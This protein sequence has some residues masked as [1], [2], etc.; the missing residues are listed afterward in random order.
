[1][2]IASRDVQRRYDKSEKG[3]KR[4]RRYASSAKGKATDSRYDKSEK[5]LARKHRF[6][7]ARKRAGLCVKCSDQAVT[8]TLCW[9]CASKHAERG[10]L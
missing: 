2:S 10:G 5:G 9:T 6:V 4:Y 8:E 7:E 3:K 1:M